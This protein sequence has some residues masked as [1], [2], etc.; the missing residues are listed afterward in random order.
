M[1]HVLSNGAVVLEFAICTA[2]FLASL[3]LET[4]GAYIAVLWNFC[5]VMCGAYEFLERGGVLGCSL[6]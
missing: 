2:A 6:F 1:E 5:G 4:S 3:S